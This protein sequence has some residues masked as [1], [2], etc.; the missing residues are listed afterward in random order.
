[1]RKPNI[2]RAKLEKRGL[3]GFF[4]RRMVVIEYS[5]H[6]N[7]FEQV[8]PFIKQ[9]ERKCSCSNKA[10]F[11]NFCLWHRLWSIWLTKLERINANINNHPRFI[12][13]VV[14]KYTD[15]YW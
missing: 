13:R 7:L 12:I 14:T 9:K 1:M 3:L 5:S 10:A 2:K 11:H 15:L 8:R 6:Q 4:P